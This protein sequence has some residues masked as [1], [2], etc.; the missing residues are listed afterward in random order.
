[1]K[2]VINLLKFHILE[3]QSAVTYGNGFSMYN[4][5]REKLAMYGVIDPLIIHETGHEWFGNSVTASDQRTSGFMKDYRFIQSKFILKI[6]LIAMKLEFTLIQSHCIVNEKFIVGNE[7]EN[8]WA[9]HGDTYMK[10][11]GYAHSKKCDKQ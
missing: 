4:G 1:M 7:N 8:H 10:G 6:N 3:H 11:D 2:M 9:L 5:V